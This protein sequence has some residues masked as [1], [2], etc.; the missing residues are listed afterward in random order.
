MKKKFR[1]GFYGEPNFLCLYRLYPN[2][3]TRRPTHIW[4][5]GITGVVKSNRQETPYT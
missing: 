2:V 5:F 3:H 1:A 4:R